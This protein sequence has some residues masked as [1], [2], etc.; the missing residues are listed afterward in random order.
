[1]TNK[2]LNVSQCAK[3]LGVTRHAVYGRIGRRTFIEGK[4]VK[5]SLGN[6][7]IRYHIDDV[8]AFRDRKK[9]VFEPVE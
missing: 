1:M 4:K 7:S 6:I 5:D 2:W 9:D 3:I 8:I